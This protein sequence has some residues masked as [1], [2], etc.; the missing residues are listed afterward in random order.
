M[1]DLLRR[2]APRKGGGA[3]FLIGAGCSISAG[4]VAAAGVAQHCALTLARKLSG[5]AFHEK[6]ADAALD[7]LIGES[8]VAIPN[9]SKPRS[10][11]THWAKLYGYFFESH[12]QSANQ[13]RE[14]INAIVEKGEGKLNWAHAC[15]GELVRLGFVHT[16]LTTNFDQLVLEGI[17]R[18]G[19]VPVVAD[20]LEALNRIDGRPKRRQLVH[21][22]G[23]MHTY[24]LRNSPT[25]LAEPSRHGVAKAT[26]HTLMRDCDLLVV[27]G[28]GGGEEGIM[29]LLK[30]AARVMPLVVYWVTYTQ[31]LGD[32]SPN[33][34]MLLHGENKFVVWGG[35]ADRFFGQ[36]MSELKLGEPE[37]VKDPVGVMKK[38]SERLLA[39]DKD[40]PELCILVEAFR[41]RVDHA[42]DPAQRLVESDSRKIR[43]AALR[44][45]GEFLASNEALGTVGLDDDVGAARLHFLNLLSLLERQRQHD[46]ELLSA[47]I[48][49][50]DGLVRRTAG[51]SKLDNVLS[52]VQALTLRSEHA[53]LTDDTAE[54]ARA[55]IR[56]AEQLISDT[57]PEYPREID[58]V[59][60]MRLNLLL[61]QSLQS[62]GERQPV[63]MELLEASEAAYDEALAGSQA[64]EDV[65]GLIEAM[66]GLAALHQVVGEETGNLE[67]LKDAVREQKEVV[68]LSPR[69]DRLPRGCGPPPQSC[70]SSDRT[71]Q[72][73]DGRRIPSGVS[74]R[75]GDAGPSGR[76]RPGGR[77]TTGS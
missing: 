8:R 66:A 10:D 56:R 62:R 76:I 44:A 24:E 34:R 73:R 61:A 41:A 71:R 48:D 68:A 55:P 77:R 9:A 12:F 43:A 42:N 27:V 38:Q 28:Y 14:I 2:A 19:I 72:T 49:G 36:L 31:G 46:G 40:L 11:G 22:H 47:A 60:N 57:L 37:W 45:R 74:G 59:G 1:R 35:T 69:T 16:V 39:P 32:L 26:V 54:A 63:D 6:E 25:S 33:A 20:G 53:A 5:R 58:A 30:D 64:T 51:Q 29:T 23:S 4:I 18:T 67:L 75:Q 50:F 21:L 17:I 13:Q 52:L 65:E 15:L 7:W 70:R 3:V